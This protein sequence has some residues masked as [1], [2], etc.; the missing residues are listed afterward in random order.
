V[1]LI[2]FCICHRQRENDRRQSLGIVISSCD[3]WDGTNAILY[4]MSE[5][6]SKFLAG[7]SEQLIK[8]RSND[9]PFDYSSE[10][11]EIDNKVVYELGNELVTDVLGNEIAGKTHNE[12][13]GETDTTKNSSQADD[14]GFTEIDLHQ[15]PTTLTGNE[16]R[17]SNLQSDISTDGLYDSTKL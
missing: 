15:Q 7:R 14:T 10:A 3:E 4:A 9:S 16:A 17:R 12:I 8:S 13:T 5:E 1:I 6:N 2:Y 11:D